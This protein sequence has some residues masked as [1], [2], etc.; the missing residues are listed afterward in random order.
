MSAL[1]FGFFHSSTF[2]SIIAN[3]ANQKRVQL[4]ALVCPVEVAGNPESGLKRQQRFKAKTFGSVVV[5]TLC[6]RGA[7]SR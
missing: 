2:P 7:L 3:T 6:H 4:Q 5:P 1:C